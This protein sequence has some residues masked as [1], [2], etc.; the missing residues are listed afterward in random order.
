MGSNPRDGVQEAG[1]W[2]GQMMDGDGGVQQH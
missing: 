2:G 1:G